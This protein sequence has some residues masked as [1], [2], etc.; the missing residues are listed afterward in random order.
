MKYHELCHTTEALIRVI[1]THCNLPVILHSVYF[2]QLSPEKTAVI[3]SPPHINGF[4][5][6]WNHTQIELAQAAKLSFRNWR[7][8]ENDIPRDRPLKKS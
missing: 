5:Q 1:K 3:C 7:K 8:S 6:L 4:L 2:K